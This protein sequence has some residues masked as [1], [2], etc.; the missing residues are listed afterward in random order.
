M[1]ELV[2]V[3]VVLSATFLGFVIGYLV[4]GPIFTQIALWAVGEDGSNRELFTH[5]RH[6]LPIMLATFAL[7]A[8][9][10]FIAGFSVERLVN[11]FGVPGLVPS[12]SDEFERGT[13][14]L[15]LTASLAAE[16]AKTEHVTLFERSVGAAALLEFLGA[17]PG[18]AL[19]LPGASGTELRL[20]RGRPGPDTADPDK[21]P[22]LVT[23]KEHGRPQYCFETVMPGKFVRPEAQYV[24]FCRFTLRYVGCEDELDASLTFKGPF[25][26]MRTVFFRS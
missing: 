8:I 20:T 16:G 9:T 15:A 12:A 22:I 6:G 5:I 10:A 11:R 2:K 21:V 23:L 24:A 18:T 1:K 14:K 3:V 17:E 4:G 26:V 13:V 19:R 7:A 25:T